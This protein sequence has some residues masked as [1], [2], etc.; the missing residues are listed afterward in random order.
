MVYSK[1]YFVRR[2]WLLS[3]CASVNKTEPLLT[4]TLLGG[5]YILNVRHFRGLIDE[6]GHNGRVL[7]SINNKP[8][9]MKS[10]P[11][12]STETEENK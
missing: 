12:I 7:I 4:H 3:V 10:L 6:N 11:E 9:R 5:T 2:L 1:K 8:H